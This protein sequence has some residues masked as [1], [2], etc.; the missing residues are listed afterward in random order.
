MNL[1]RWRLLSLFHYIVLIGSHFVSGQRSLPFQFRPDRN[2]ASGALF[3][4]PLS[5]PICVLLFLS[6][7]Y[8]MFS[9]STW[10][11]SRLPFPM[12][13][14]RGYLVCFFHPSPRLLYWVLWLL[15]N[16]SCLFNTSPWPQSP[17]SGLDFA[18]ILW[19]TRWTENGNSSPDVSASC[20][21]PR[22]L[23]F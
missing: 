8:F 22:S 6:L 14:S 15:L 2:R 13:R 12:N 4:L 20:L 9:T 18:H 10:S 1:C 3:S 5:P 11:Q 16:S 7:I 17:L 21:V 19:V 23:H